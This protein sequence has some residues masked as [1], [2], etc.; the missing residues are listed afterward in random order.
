MSKRERFF[1]E[2]TEALRQI[3]TP[4]GVMLTVRLA[5]RTDRAVAFVIDVSIWCLLLFLIFLSAVLLQSSR[6]GN[7]ALVPL[8]LFAAFVIRMSYFIH[9]ELAWQGATPGKRITGL[10]V[11][12]RQGGPLLPSAVIARN[13]TREFEIFLPIG[14]SLSLSSAAD[15]GVASLLSMLWILCIGALPLL[16]RDR[17]R[18]GDLIAGTMVIA[19]SRRGLAADLAEGDFHYTFS[20][21]QLMAYGAF[22]LQ[23]L[24]ELLRGAKGGNS[25]ELMRSVGER[26]RRKIGRTED[27]PPERELLFLRDFY[28][29]ERRFLEGQQ[30]L[31]RLAEAEDEQR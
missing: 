11:I 15:R 18:G 2:K 16:N 4:E 23:V 14:V 19:L 20:D 24:E 9:F 31:G 7:A 10:R 13:L 12:D 29:A 6:V 17:L 8:L 27:V 21:Q 1:D 22:E 3:L 28:A 30:L 5:D 26:I 25:A